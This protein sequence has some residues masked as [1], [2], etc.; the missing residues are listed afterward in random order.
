[1]STLL[2][3]IMSLAG[4]S[5][6]SA[7]ASRTGLS[8][9]SAG[10]GLKT[11][12][13]ALLGAMASRSGE[14]GLMPQILQLAQSAL[15]QGVL[16]SLG[17][18]AK[19]ESGGAAGELTN[20]MLAALFGTQR[21]STEAALAKVTG[22]SANSL[23]GLLSLAAPMVLGFLGKK[24]ADEGLSA[25]G[26][27]SSLSAEWPALQRSLPGGLAA[28]MSG[29]GPATAAFHA[30]ASEAQQGGKWIMPLALGA[31]LAAGILYLMTRGTGAMP[32]PVKTPAPVVAAPA[33]EAP[34]HWVIP[35]LGEFSKRRLPNG[36]ELDIPQ[37]GIESKLIQ[38]IE[39]ASKPVDKTTWFDFDRLLFDTAKATLQP[40]SQE[41]LDNVAAILKAYPN[42]H[43]KLGGYTDNVGDKAANMKLS[44]DRATNV[45]SELVKL[46]IDSARLSAEGYGDQH[47][48]ASNDT[49]EGRQQNR[50]TS[51]R[52][53]QK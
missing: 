44:Q 47:P 40:K 42:V 46:G 38:F 18:I 3:S 19:G 23:S 31:A 26:L 13:A 10:S 34:S 27:A 43:I 52:V 29:A 15:G 50:R 39:D 9:S 22:T 7:L 1:M 49:E 45:M 41:Q 4:P 14:S 35:A 12:A 2:D 24:S 5:L 28:L 51:L 6:L 33:V 20:G 21:S 36:V 30:Y 53:T 32:E 48:V 17:S 11:C 25:V 8:E 37:L 16:G